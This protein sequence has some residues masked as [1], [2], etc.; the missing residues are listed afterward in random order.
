MDEKAKAELEAM[1]IKVSSMTQEE[2][3]SLPILIHPVNVSR[4]SKT[5]TPNNKQ[6]NVPKNGGGIERETVE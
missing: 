3:D 1:G 2:A 4:K 5:D 6:Q